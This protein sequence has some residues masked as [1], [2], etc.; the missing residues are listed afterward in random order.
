MQTLNPARP[1]SGSFAG[2]RRASTLECVESQLS[3]SRLLLQG[4]LLSNPVRSSM[5]NPGR[6]LL[7]HIVTT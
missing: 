4:P 3:P 7:K 5:L 6:R 2:K 1:I